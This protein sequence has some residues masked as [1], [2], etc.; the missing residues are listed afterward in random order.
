MPGE[1][2]GSGWRLPQRIKPLPVDLL[3]TP[4]ARADLIEIYSYI[5]LDNPSAAERIFDA[6]EAKAGLL[7]D[8]PRLGV[9]R[10]EIR[11]STRMLIEG[12]Y[13]ILYETHPD[14][15]VGSI[16]EVEIVRIVDGRR[17]LKSLF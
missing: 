8:Y 1:K 15:D 11:P 16:D 12:P 7:V 3:W 14:S 9:R 4:Q 10:P 13:L 5:A 17:N 2:H 6:V